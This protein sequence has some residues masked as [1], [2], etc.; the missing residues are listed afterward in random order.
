MRL[1]QA[2]K[3]VGNY[4][5]RTAAK[6]WQAV[7]HEMSRMRTVSDD[8]MRRANARVDRRY[9]REMKKLKA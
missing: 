2:W 7:F 9:N 4:H 5:S 6:F 8:K 1:R 3:I